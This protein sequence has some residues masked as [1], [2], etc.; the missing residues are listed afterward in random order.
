MGWSRTLSIQLNA[1]SPVSIRWA[2]L[3]VA[4]QVAAATVTFSLSSVEFI[5]RIS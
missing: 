4:F 3:H 5:L 2:L 1:P